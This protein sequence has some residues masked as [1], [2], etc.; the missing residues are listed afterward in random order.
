MR[1]LT[2]SE[3]YLER[4]KASIRKAQQDQT[5]LR[6][7]QMLSPKI[8]EKQKGK[9]RN[10]VDTIAREATQS[11]HEESSENDGSKVREVFSAMEL[12]ESERRDITARRSL[13]RSERKPA[14]NPK[15]LLTKKLRSRSRDRRYTVDSGAAIL[16]QFKAVST[17]EIK[18]EAPSRKH[19]V[20]KPFL[21]R[22]IPSRANA[23]D[24]HDRLME[25]Y[26]K[27]LAAE[28]DLKEAEYDD[29]DS[30]QDDLRYCISRLDAVMHDIYNAYEHNTRDH[31]SG[32]ETQDTTDVNTSNSEPS[33]YDRPAV[34]VI[35]RSF[36]I[37]QKDGMITRHEVG[38]MQCQV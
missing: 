16:D 15:D 4:T 7:Y 20:S 23:P 12:K 3:Q 14:R 5:E 21:K 31:D 28:E 10:S 13:G 22:Y 32:E 34:T 9:S 1:R 33:P 2:P 29:H 30:A 18:A 24:V 25:I 6:L 36:S 35:N 38:M 17:Q 8:G 11:R 26:E 19:C 27:R 37:S